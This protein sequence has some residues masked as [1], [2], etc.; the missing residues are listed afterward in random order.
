M[1]LEALSELNQ[2]EKLRGLRE[3]VYELTD[4]Y[5]I[6]ALHSALS[7]P[8]IAR[9]HSRIWRSF[10]N[11][12][13]VWTPSTGFFIRFI[14]VALH[15]ENLLM[16]CVVRPLSNCHSIYHLSYR[17]VVESTNH[18]SLC[19]Y[20]ETDGSVLR[21]FEANRRNSFSPHHPESTTRL[22][23]ALVFHSWRFWGGARVTFSRP[24]APS[25]CPSRISL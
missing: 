19:T 5:Y 18:S 12:T 9:I 21:S 2:T 4:G 15:R 25:R 23:F 6:A 16:A 20:S 3:Y 24:V 8:K 13:T 7:Y 17:F 11:P 1:R 10:E 14:S 22:H